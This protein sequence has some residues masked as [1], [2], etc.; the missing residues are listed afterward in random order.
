MGGVITELKKL[1]VVVLSTPSA[2]PVLLLKVRTLPLMTT[3]NCVGPTAPIESGGK[4]LA[5][6]RVAAVKL[7][8]TVCESGEIGEAGGAGC[9]ADGPLGSQR[10]GHAES[11][12]GSNVCFGARGLGLRTSAFL[13]SASWLSRAISQAVLS[14][15]PISPAHGVPITSGS[16]TAGTVSGEPRIRLQ[17]SANQP[18]HRGED[19]ILQA[20]RQAGPNKQRL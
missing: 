14:R 10:A 16:F 17:P 12:T 5:S 13:A 6:A 3:R 2:A 7:K 8:P 15:T 9:P 18:I 4:P 20:R 1:S 11:G 19:F